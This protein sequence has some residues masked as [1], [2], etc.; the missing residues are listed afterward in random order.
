[1]KIIQQKDFI[2]GSGGGRKIA[3]GCY[4][5]VYSLQFQVS[6]LQILFSLF[7]K[8]VTYFVDDMCDSLPRL[9]DYRISSD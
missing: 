4:C 2:E 9:Q 7:N 1:M 3:V 6:F 8:C 5:C